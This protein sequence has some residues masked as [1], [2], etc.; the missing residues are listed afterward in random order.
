[1]LEPM[2]RVERAVDWMNECS[3]MREVQE[4]DAFVLGRKMREFREARGKSLRKAAQAMK[5]TPPYLSDCE[6]GFRKLNEERLQRF[7]DFCEK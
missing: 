4:V 6:R 3:S 7:I 2:K 1:M 5:I